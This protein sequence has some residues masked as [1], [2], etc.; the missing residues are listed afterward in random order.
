[1][2]S[3][4]GRERSFNHRAMCHEPI[5]ITHTHTHIHTP[6]AHPVLSHSNTCAHGQRF[7]L[8]HIH[9]VDRAVARKMRI[10][11]IRNP[12]WIRKQTPTPMQIYKHP[13][14]EALCN[15]CSERVFF[16]RFSSQNK[17]VF[18]SRSSP[19]HSGLGNSHSGNIP[20]AIST[21]T[22]PPQKHTYTPTV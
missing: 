9:K 6:I 2:T 19:C 21:H 8:S 4:Q 14:P 7:R 13:K 22:P 17:D 5:F 20:Y 16:I 10:Q 18:L 11:Y 1:M 15:E 3:T 12:N